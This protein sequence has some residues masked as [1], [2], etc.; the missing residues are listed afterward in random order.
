MKYYWFCWE[1]TTKFGVS[2]YEDVST[3]HPFIVK[4]KIQK[5]NGG[6]VTLLNYK[7][8]SKEEF[9]L[10]DEMSVELNS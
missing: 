9:E 10:Y 3:K 4:V 5:R 8:I 7:E 1:H 6:V 2:R